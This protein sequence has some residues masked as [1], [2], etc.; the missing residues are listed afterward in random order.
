[1]NSIEHFIN[2]PRFRA[3]VNSPSQEEDLF[4]QDY[5]KNNPA[6]RENV[7]KAKLLLLHNKQQK[8]NPETD[9]WHKLQGQITEKPIRK[10]YLNWKQI[11]VAASVVLC[12]GLGLFFTINNSESI[13]YKTTFNQK[14]IFILSDS[15]EVTLN[16]NSE[17]T[18]NNDW[19]SGESRQVFL[20]GE[21]YFKVR[22]KAQKTPFEVHTEHLDVQVLGTI[23]NVLS[24][25]SETNVML[26]EGK[27]QITTPTEK[28]LMK[29]NELITWTKKGLV[30]SSVLASDYNAWL[31]NELIFKGS[32]LVEVTQKLQDLYGYKISLN[33]TVAQKK[34]TAILPSQNPEIV[35][36]AIVTTFDL[37]MKRDGNKVILE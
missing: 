17:L 10:L 3:W 6:D 11:A 21:G 35:L 14:K 34:F 24:R 12:I 22:K 20:K 33:P 26:E 37:K 28:Q 32:T 30:K 19:N 23:F 5:L 15:S 18:L 2:N 16:A 13:T 29:P 1:M 36:K 9:D 8:Q 31:R 25:K 27:V 4:W 7:A